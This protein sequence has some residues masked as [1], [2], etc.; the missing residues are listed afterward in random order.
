VGWRERV[1]HGVWERLWNGAVQNEQ[2]PAHVR[3]LQGVLR[4]SCGGYTLAPTKTTTTART[5]RAP[6]AFAL[7]DL[8]EVSIKR[9]TLATKPAESNGAAALEL[10]RAHT[11]LEK[12]DPGKDKSRGFPRDRQVGEEGFEPPKALASRF[13]VCPDWPLRHSPCMYRPSGTGSPGGQGARLG[14]L[15]R[16]GNRSGAV[17]LLSIWIVRIAR[18]PERKTADTTSESR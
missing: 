4:F 17:F 10:C 3:G 1:G 6:L 8:A 14:R 15:P 5:P 12:T 9:R 7:V 13:T 16:G 2:P 18:E 11:D